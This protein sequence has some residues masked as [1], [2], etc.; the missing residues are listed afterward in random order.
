MKKKR[1]REKRARRLHILERQAL[2]V[3]REG[4]LRRLSGYW[5][6]GME[7]SKR[8]L[9]TYLFYI[10]AMSAAYGYFT[11]LSG[12]VGYWLN[13]AVLIPSVMLFSSFLTMEGRRR[14]GEI[15]PDELSRFYLYTIDGALKKEARE[16]EIEES[17]PREAD[18]DEEQA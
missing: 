8:E 5:L 1:E 12:K 17:A 15:Y 13:L 16:R 6:F 14:R 2:T 11:Y 3:Y 10:V 7:K 9:F 4:R 18:S